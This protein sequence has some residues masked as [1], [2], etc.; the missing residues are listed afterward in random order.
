MKSI[1]PP[2]VIFAA[3]FILM[4][5]DERSSGI[6]LELHEIMLRNR[7]D[8]IS[9]PLWPFD[10]TE[11]AFLTPNLNVEN[12]IRIAEI[13]RRQAA[14]I[15]VPTV[16]GVS[17]FAIQRISHL[18]SFIE[19]AKLV[20]EI[21]FMFDLLRYGYAGYQYF[22]GDDVFL[23]LRK[24]MLEKLEG[25]PN[26]LRVSSY[27]TDI[28]VPPLRDVI[29]D[30]HFMVHD[31][32]MEAPRYTLFMN[33]D[34]VIRNTRNGFMTEV[35]NSAHKILEITA[36]DGQPI[37]GI[38]PTLTAQGE[39]AWT[40]G[41]MASVSDFNAREM[42]V[43][44]ED[45]ITGE[46]HSRT[47]HL[48]RIDPL[49]RRTATLLSQRKIAGVTVLEHTYGF[50][51]APEVL[52]EFFY[53][54]DS[55]RNKS[56]FVLDLQGHR[57][58]FRSLRHEWLRGYAGEDSVNI[59]ALNEFGLVTFTSMEL[60][61][62]PPDA[63]QRFVDETEIAPPDWILP[64]VPPNQ[65][66]PN[67]NL[68]IVLM[69][70]ETSSLGEMFVAHLRQLE[71][72]LFVGANT[73]GAIAFTSIVRTVM[74]YSELDIMFGTTLNLRPNLSQLEGVGFMP[75]LWVPPGESLER[76]LR[77]IERYGLAR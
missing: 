28:L 65:I 36:R 17:P 62:V 53:S 45:A 66:I 4:A 22:G 13:V 43:S 31:R 24:S 33:E 32:R 16:P 7:T 19:H 6:P 25:L 20:S 67:E 51:Y 14:R 11:M 47:V 46:R 69:D 10:E 40:F 34:F 41:L 44:F 38:L 58:G 21:Y 57:G 2:I 49:P 60:H 15:I 9:M 37:E 23:P 70:N 39:F 8:S 54:G 63:V 3:I 18:T 30:N 35:D 52:A 74:P 42:T 61:R 50:S 73:R 72:V 76:V 64:T 55:M 12:D 29:A 71:N 75:D 59:L 48:R 26:P 68:V 77:F 56:L 1:A 27:L 5:C